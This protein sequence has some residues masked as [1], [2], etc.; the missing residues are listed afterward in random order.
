MNTTVSLRIKSFK[1]NHSESYE[2]RI[3][4][5]NLVEKRQEIFTLFIINF[6]MH[7]EVN[8]ISLKLNSGIIC[9]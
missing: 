5:N 9:V 2:Y 6:Q 4:F 7:N 8:H 1:K 3:N